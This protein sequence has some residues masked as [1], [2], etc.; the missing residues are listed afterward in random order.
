MSVSA[1]SNP[2]SPQTFPHFLATVN[3]PIVCF[4]NRFLRGSRISISLEVSTLSSADQ[5]VVVF[6]CPKYRYYSTDPLQECLSAGLPLGPPISG[7]AIAAGW[8]THG[9]VWVRTCNLFSVV[10]VR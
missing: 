6:V 3:L 7:E 5:V 4:Q 2:F 10:P 9:S 8:P 1:T